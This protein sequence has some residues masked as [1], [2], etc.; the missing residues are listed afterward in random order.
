VVIPAY[1]EELRL[2]PSLHR[3]LDYLQEQG[4]SFEVLVADD[5]SQDGTARVAEAAGQSVTLVSLEAHAGKGAAVRAAVLRSA[6]E[7]ILISDADLATPI[8]EL[9]RLEARLSDGVGMVIGSRALPGARVAG[10]P[11]HRRL[12]SGAFNL[13]VRLALVP[14]I[15]DTQCGFKLLRGELARTV[16]RSCHTAGF[17]FDVEVILRVRRLGL[18]VVEVPVAWRDMPGSRVRPVPDSLSM[19]W[20]LV[21]LR[22]TRPGDEGESSQSP[23]AEVSIAGQ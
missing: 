19:A 1:N 22:L 14:G 8:E 21:R 4:E 2:P 7:L 11:A 12:L 10:R 5:G 3:L 15:R 13:A 20:E 18:Q 23:L 17:T 9:R 16:F 6:G